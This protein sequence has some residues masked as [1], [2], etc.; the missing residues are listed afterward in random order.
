MPSSYLQYAQD[1]DG[2]GRRDIWATPADVFA[3]IANYL[4]GHGWTTGEPWGREV[5]ISKAAERIIAREIARRDGTCQATRDMTVA[6]P[7][8]R[9]EA[10]GVRTMGGGKLPSR[11][12]DAALVSGA[13]RHF[14]VY[15]NYDALLEY[16]C[17]HSYA[18][19]VAL[20]ADRLTKPAATSRRRPSKRKR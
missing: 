3:S 5:K 6:L 19:S 13:S 1:Y 11:T 10:I 7:A 4:V 16:N 17:A 15:R 9:W 2:D 20:L 18:L 14:L 8:K 12:P